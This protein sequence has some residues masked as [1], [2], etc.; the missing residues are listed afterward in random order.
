[1]C[2]FS[3]STNFVD[4]LKRKLDGV[5]QR[6]CDLEY[7]AKNSDKDSMDLKTTKNALDEHKVDLTIFFCYFIYIR[8]HTSTYIYIFFMHLIFPSI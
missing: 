4:Y 8:R 6:L 5:D 3:S 1:V 7:S 2:I